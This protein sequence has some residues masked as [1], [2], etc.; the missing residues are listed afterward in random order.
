MP[1]PRHTSALIAS[2]T[3]SPPGDGTAECE[4]SRH[5]SPTPMFVH[6]TPLISPEWDARLSRDSATINLCGTCQDN[7]VALQHIL[8]TSKG[9]A[10]WAVRREFGNDIRRLA[11]EAWD[12]Y[13][14]KARA[15]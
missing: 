8:L 6:A 5:H 4:G 2:G 10:P 7:F 11:T 3:L 15:S 13:T 12:S 9:R 14:V 1:A